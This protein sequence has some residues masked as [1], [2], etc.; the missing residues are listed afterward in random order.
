MPVGNNNSV[1]YIDYLQKVWQNKVI[2]YWFFHTRSQAV[3]LQNLSQKSNVLLINGKGYAKENKDCR[4]GL[5]SNKQ[6]SYQGQPKVIAKFDNSSS[7]IK[8]L[9]RISGI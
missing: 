7:Y 8:Q 9:L 3:H 5:Y 2:P 1:L 6:I 4:V